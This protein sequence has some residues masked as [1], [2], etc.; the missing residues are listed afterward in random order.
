MRTTASASPLRALLAPTPRPRRSAT[1]RGSREA[2]LPTEMGGC[3]IDTAFSRADSDFSMSLLK[4]WRTLV[5]HNP[6]FALDEGGAS[7]YPAIAAAIATYESALSDWK[8]VCEKRTARDKT[9]YYRSWLRFRNSF[10]F[11]TR[12]PRDAAPS[13]RSCPSRPQGRRHIVMCQCVPGAQGVDGCRSPSDHCTA[14]LARTAALRHGGEACLDFKDSAS[15]LLEACGKVQ[16][17]HTEHPR[18]LAWPHS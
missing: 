13:C 14:V 7:K 18:Q 12:P 3:N 15:P 2:Q 4:N 11:T 6:D 5:A 10:V 8:E 1:S 9:K 16:A 17:D